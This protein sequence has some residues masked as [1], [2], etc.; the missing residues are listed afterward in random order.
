MCRK[1]CKIFRPQRSVAA[2]QFQNLQTVGDPAL[3]VDPGKPALTVG[4]IV[5]VQPDAGGDIGGILILV[6][7]TLLH[8]GQMDQFQHVAPV[9]LL[10][11]FDGTDRILNGA[12][13][14]LHLF[15]AVLY[16]LF[17]EIQRI[18]QKMIIDIADGHLPDF[19]QRKA[20]I[21]QQEDLLQPCQ[22]GIRVKACT[23]T[24]YIRR[25]QDVLPVIITDGPDGYAG[26]TCKL[27]GGVITRK[28]HG[29]FSFLNVTTSGGIHPGRS[30]LPSGTSG[31]NSWH[32]PRR[33]LFRWLR[34]SG[35]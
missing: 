24:I 9:D 17:L 31:K 27:S 29:S 18:F 3:F 25:L 8:T 12:L 30:P 7:K 34:R 32:P 5:S 20:Q 35:P 19:V 14:Q 28:I 15:D 16:Q 21:F 26:H 2:S 23:G 4:G 11:L 6:L 22:I 33:I 1:K 13:Y 10:F